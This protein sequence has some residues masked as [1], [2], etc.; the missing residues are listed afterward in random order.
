LHD[1]GVPLVDV[2]SYCP[3][4]KIGDYYHH[5]RGSSILCHDLKN[6]KCV[7]TMVLSDKCHCGLAIYRGRLV[8]ANY[9]KR[10]VVIFSIRL[11]NGAPIGGVEVGFI[12]SPTLSNTASLVTLNCELYAITRQ[13]LDNKMYRYDEQQRRWEPRA[14]LVVGRCFAVAAI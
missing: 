12:A 4:V 3:G 5:Q 7:A 13:Q 6:N 14:T 8:M 10:E 11:I 9:D 1:D 2:E